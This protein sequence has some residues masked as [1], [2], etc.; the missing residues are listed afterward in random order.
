MPMRQRQTV[1]ERRILGFFLVLL[2]LIGCSLPFLCIPGL[3]EGYPAGIQGWEYR[4]GISPAENAGS[5]ALVRVRVEEPKAGK[6]TFFPVELPE[7][8][9]AGISGQN[10]RGKDTGIPGLRLG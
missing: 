6:I 2:A 10:G 9:P 1:R 4:S 5:G 3:A 7:E 8:E